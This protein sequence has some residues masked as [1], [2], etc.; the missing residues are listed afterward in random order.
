MPEP[1]RVAGV[2]DDEFMDDGV[3]DANDNYSALYE[4]GLLWSQSCVLWFQ[5][6]AGHA[7]L[8]S[9]LVLLLACA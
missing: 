8:T 4:V 1:S 3:T 5:I 9:H 2:F 6:G 7:G